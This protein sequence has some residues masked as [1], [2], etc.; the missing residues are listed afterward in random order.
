M[1][2]GILSSTAGAA[3]ILI[4]PKVGFHGVFQL[5]RPF[6]LEVSLENIGRPAEGIA[7]DLVVSLATVRSQI[8]SL[9]LKLGVHSQLAAVAM[10]RCAGWPGG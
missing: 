8:R 9:L 6:P 3:E 7:K 5:G 4:E 2:L 1:F 10:A